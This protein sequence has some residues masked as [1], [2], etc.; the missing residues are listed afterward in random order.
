MIQ[1]VVQDLVT[2][3]ASAS[4]SA[5]SVNRLHL[6]KEEKSMGVIQKLI[7]WNMKRKEHMNPSWG[8]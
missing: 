7:Q 2:S 5:D 6:P 4:K 1:V 3:S 8:G